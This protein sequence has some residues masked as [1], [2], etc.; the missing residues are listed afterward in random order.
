LG[1]SSIV[2][3]IHNVGSVQR[4]VDMARLVYSLDL[5][6]LVASKVYGAAAQSGVPEVMRLAFKA[7]R[8]F[9]VLPDIGDAVELLKPDVTLVVSLDY[10][11]DFIDPF[12]PPVYSGRLLVVFNGGEPDFSASEA[13]VGKPV[14][15]RGVSR[16]LGAVAEASIILYSLLSRTRRGGVEV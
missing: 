10:A 9:L 4:L 1:V 3:L 8:G 15:I 16:R 13:R 11:E 2:P 12:N 14:Y 6:L 5:E 7:N